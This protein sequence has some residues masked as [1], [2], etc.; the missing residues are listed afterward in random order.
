MIFGERSNGKTYGA[1]KYALEKY[2]D[3]GKQFAIIRRWQEDIKQKSGSSMFN[4]LISNGVIY[5]VTNGKYTSVF[6]KSNQW[7]FCNV[8]D[9][10]REVDER[11]FAYAF[12]LTSWE[13]DKGGSYP[14]IDTI[15]FDEFIT[16]GRYLPDEFVIFMN[17]VS[18]IVRYRDNVEIFMLGNTVSK[19]G[20]P[21]FTEMGLK[22]IPKM[23]QGSIDVYNF[24]DSK[25]QVAVEYADSPSK[26]GKLSDRYFA[27]DN[28]KLNMITGGVWEMN[29]Y[30]HIPFKFTDSDVVFRYFIV[31]YDNIL[32]CNVVSK[33]NQLMTY[34]HRKT[35]PLKDE[36]VDLIYTTDY[37]PKCNYRRKITKPATQVEQKLYS[38]FV[39]DKV[40]Y[41]DNEIGEIVRS[42]L[43]WCRTDKIV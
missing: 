31:F 26:S 39:N 5:D 14:D 6:Y 23:Q 10:G 24:G 41:Q 36:D 18:T 1:L 43:D 7:F 37:N 30:P 15:I 28:P 42:Y 19:Y 20:C 9:K 12:S 4:A 17:V 8:T 16:R 38:F 29:V 32:Q 27:F 34:I 21:Y 35:T 22:N 33:N 40:F 25:L 3:T 13:H 2:K 11:P